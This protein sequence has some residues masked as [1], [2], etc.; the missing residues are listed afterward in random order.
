MDVKP[1][2]PQLSF[3]DIKIILKKSWE[4]LRFL[5]MKGSRFL[6]TD[7]PNRK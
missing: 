2:Y 3:G 6:S 1:E 5:Y 4:L 7:M